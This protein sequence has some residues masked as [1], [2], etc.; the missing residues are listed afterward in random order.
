MNTVTSGKESSGPVWHELYRAALF[1]KEREK[2][3]Q[4]IVDAENAI[5]L[6]MRELF[7]LQTDHIEEDVVLDD[8]MYALRA[9]R[10]CVVPEAT[11][12]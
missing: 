9:L 2:I 3:P 4:R 7:V 5:R 8:A 11:A 6:R 10:S 12:A 1:E